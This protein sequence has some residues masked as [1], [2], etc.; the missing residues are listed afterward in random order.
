MSTLKEL[1]TQFVTAAP[2]RRFV[3]MHER[4]RPQE[5]RESTWKSSL[6]WL[7]AAAL[8][9][10]GVILTIMPTP[11]GF[12]FVVAGLGLLIGRSRR[13]AEWCDR[14]EL[15]VRRL[16]ARARREGHR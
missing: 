11:F 3:A 16:W 7:L 13:M 14:A 6:A 5:R 9:V 12:L 1:F 2:G 4:R 8:F 15:S 10:A